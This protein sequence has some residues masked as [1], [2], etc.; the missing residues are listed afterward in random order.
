MGLWDS[1]FSWFCR[2]RLTSTCV[3]NT[4]FT[5]IA[6]DECSMNMQAAAA[7]TTGQRAIMLCTQ[8]MSPTCVLA[9]QFHQSTHSNQ[10]LHHMKNVVLNRHPKHLADA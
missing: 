3:A 6:Y 1:S 8:G 9:V 5:I 2:D 7:Y 10:L 4:A